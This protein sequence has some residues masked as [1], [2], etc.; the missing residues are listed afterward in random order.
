MN[1]LS[2]LWPIQKGHFVWCPQRHYLDAG[3]CNHCKTVVYAWAVVLTVTVGIL[4]YWTSTVTGSLPLRSDAWHMF[5]DA[6]GYGIGIVHSSVAVTFF[7]MQRNIELPKKVTEGAMAVFL[8]FTIVIILIETGERLFQGKPPD[9][10]QGNLLFW[11]AVLGLVVNAVLFPLLRSLGIEHSH[12]HPH[13][14]TPHKHDEQGHE[15][16]EGHQHSHKSGKDMVLQANIKHTLTDLISS[17][18][19]VGSTVIYA[20]YPDF[21]RFVDVAVPLL[22]VCILGDQIWKIVQGWIRDGD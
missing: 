18:A 16:K 17:L 15:H 12:P 22:V 3:G 9:I 19:V 2:Q 7:L 6:L 21:V 5:S 8:S 13:S 10:V 1:A 4:E 11:V 14:H 20:R